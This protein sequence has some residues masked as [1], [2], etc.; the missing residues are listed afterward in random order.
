MLV[1]SLGCAYYVIA[2]KTVCEFPSFPATPATTE[3]NQSLVHTE[4][5]RRLYL[6]LY[7]HL[8]IGLWC[9]QARDW[10]DLECRFPLNLIGGLY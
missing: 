3:G 8:I 6:D 4:P 1:L 7:I 5:T 9:F 10:R 2:H